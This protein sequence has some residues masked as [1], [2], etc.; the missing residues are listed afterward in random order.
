MSPADFEARLEDELYSMYAGKHICGVDAEP[1]VTEKKTQ[2]FDKISAKINEMHQKSGG[3]GTSGL[4]L[5]NK[6]WNNLTIYL[7][8]DG[9]KSKFVVGWRSFLN[10]FTINVD[11]LDLTV[12]G[13]V[14][15]TI[16]WK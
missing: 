4:I 15:N 5:P 12:E 7:E 6:N 13:A 10:I 3:M 11:T 14:K 2:I 8:L 9:N 1:I 16:A